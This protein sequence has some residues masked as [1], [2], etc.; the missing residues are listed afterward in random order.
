MS[1]PTSS[2]GQISLRQLLGDHPQR[3]YVFLVRTETEPAVFHRYRRREQALFKQVIEV[4]GGECSGAVILRGA[5]RKSFAC[6]RTH[7]V[8]ELSLV[9][10]EIE[11]SVEIHLALLM[12]MIPTEISRP[13]TF[14]LEGVVAIDYENAFVQIRGEH[15]FHELKI[16]VGFK[17][18]GFV[19]IDADR[20]DRGFH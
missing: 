8:Y 20:I 4:I 2:Q 15:C 11:L 1:F 19:R 7:S 6:E 12:K 18:D 13:A 16:V 14:I 10:V 3:E 17:A 5:R 9:R